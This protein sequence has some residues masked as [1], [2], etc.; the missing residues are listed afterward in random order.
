MVIYE[1]GEEASSVATET[2]IMLIL[3]LRGYDAMHINGLDDEKSRTFWCISLL[4]I[5]AQFLCLGFAQEQFVC[6]VN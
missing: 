1:D 6:N 4:C 5:L 3:M 2:F